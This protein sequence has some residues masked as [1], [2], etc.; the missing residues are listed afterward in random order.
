V[1][2]DEQIGFLQ[3]SIKA[4]DMK[5][6]HQHDE[7]SAL[8]K[9]KL[10]SDTIHSDK[11]AKYQERILKLKRIIAKMKQKRSSKKGQISRI[12]Q[13]K[14]RAMRIPMRGGGKSKKSKRRGKR[15]KT[16]DDG[17]DSPTGSV[18]SSYV[19]KKYQN[20]YA[21]IQFNSHNSE[22]KED[23]VASIAGSQV[24]YQSYKGVYY[25]PNTEDHQRILSPT[26]S[27]HHPNIKDL[28]DLPVDDIESVISNDNYSTYSGMTAS[29][30]TPY[31]PSYAGSSVGSCTGSYVG[32]HPSR[33]SNHVYVPTYGYAARTPQAHL[34]K[35]YWGN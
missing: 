3:N 1:E 24:S 23:D 10:E 9:L 2:K 27:Y 26:K 17:N 18:A 19:P 8:G 12:R 7:L 21:S 11:A 34:N 16:E 14:M 32:V 30:Y 25:H 4:K 31:A 20:T 29:T 13:K 35:A 5:L 15:K 33:Y 22:A 6:R 28:P